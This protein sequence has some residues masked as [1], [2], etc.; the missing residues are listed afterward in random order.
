MDPQAY[1]QLI[2][3]MAHQ[4]DSDLESFF[5][6]HGLGDAYRAPDRGWGRRKRINTALDVARK[7]GTYDAVLADAL[8]EYGEATP[9]GEAPWPPARIR[10]E[11]D[12]LAGDLGAWKAARRLDDAERYVTRLNELLGHLRA[13]GVAVPDD[14]ELIDADRTMLHIA[15]KRLRASMTTPTTGCAGSSHCSRHWSRLRQRWV[16]E[17]M[18][19]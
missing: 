10:F 13:N 8:R 18:S 12:R 6:S 5:D 19:G 14:F 11:L 2:D 16:P 17:P 1:K 3:R 9:T 4:Y 7:D 15:D